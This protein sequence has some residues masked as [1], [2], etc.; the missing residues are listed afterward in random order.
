MRVDLGWAQFRAWYPRREAWQPAEKAFRK[1]HKLGKLPDMLII[2]V[3]IKCQQM[4]GGCLQKRYVNGRDLRPLPA[5]WLNAERWHDEYEPAMKDTA[6]QAVGL[7]EERRDPGEINQ[8][9]LEAARADFFKRSKEWGR[10]T[11]QST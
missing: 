3:A 11:D 2:K 10:G 6:N 5:S 7:P 8:V 4:P 9:E 1:L